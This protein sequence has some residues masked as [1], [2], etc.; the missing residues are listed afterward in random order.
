[1]VSPG[2]RAALALASIG[3][4][5]LA[6]NSCGAAQGAVWRTLDRGLEL[7]TIAPP[8]GAA[9]SE[10]S[11]TVLR[12]DP[13]HWDLELIGIGPTGDPAG[14]TAK[15]WARQYGLAAAI[16][17]GMFD[18]DARTHIGYLRSGSHAQGRRNKYESVAAFDPRAGRPVPRF[19]LYDLDEPGITLDRIL[20]DY[21]SVVQNLR[22]IKRPGENRWGPQERRWSEAALGE[23]AA[24][25]ALF[26]FSRSPFAM[27][28]WND[29]LLSA[30]IDLVAAQH[31]EGGPKAQLFVQAGGVEVD[32]FGEF[33]GGQ[34]NMAAWPVP[35]VI[36]VK[37]R[38]AG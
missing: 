24:G 3:V 37:R 19:R 13:E 26:L 35:N 28:E 33:E 8:K 22:L 16:N 38:V 12:I 15:D 1:V 25:R 11:I 17:A 30:G 20:E 23:D 36:G 10:S 18:V 2:T 31:L 6:A 5:A 7:A 32:R 29:A 4:L 27:H 14:R 21:D 34:G 9:S